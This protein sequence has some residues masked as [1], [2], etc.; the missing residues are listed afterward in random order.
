M[1]VLGGKHFS[2]GCDNN[3]YS[4]WLSK[5]GSQTQVLKTFRTHFLT[6]Q[7]RPFYLPRQSRGGVLELRTFLSHLL[8]VATPGKDYQLLRLCQGC[9]S[10]AS[11][12]RYHLGCIGRSA[13]AA[14]RQHGIQ[15][16]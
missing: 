3:P 10:L 4:K 15:F 16:G 1:V 7:N 5:Y 14:H 13:D 11:T 9:L 8:H 12:K 6:R 2:P